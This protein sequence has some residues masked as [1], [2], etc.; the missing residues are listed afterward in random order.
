M[1]NID[2][3]QP[4]GFPLEAD[5][6]LGFM[7]SNY[8]SPLKA[9]FGQLGGNYIVSGVELNTNTNAFSDGFIWL[10]GQMIEFQGGLYNSPY[11]YVETT[12]TPKANENG[13]LVNRYTKKLAKIGTGA[14]YRPLTDLKRLHK[15]SVFQNA[16]LAYLNFDDL[17]VV[18]QGCEVNVSGNNEIVLIQSGIGI[19]GGRI[20]AIPAYQPPTPVM[21]V[22][23]EKLS[24]QDVVIWNENVPLSGQPYIAFEPKASRYLRDLRIT[25]SAFVGE[26]RMI[27][28]D[29][30]D[31]LPTGIGRF[32]MK[33]W[34][35]CN[36]L[37]GTIDMRGRIPKSEVD[38]TTSEIGENGG[39]D[40]VSIGLAHMPSHNH[41]GGAVGPGDYGL[42]R[43]SA[44]GEN[45]T[46]GGGAIDATDSGQQ[47]DITT[48]PSPIPY[49][50]NNVPLDIQNKYVKLRFIQRIL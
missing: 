41:V 48:T 21:Q 23:S 3:S 27:A 30:R 13:V 15:Q 28:V 8:Q 4:N 5:A 39:A 43:R 33:G 47:P 18:I 34:A 40:T 10:D 17:P 22:Y 14:G 6:T 12:I 45:V 38:F 20:C 26:I 11:F 32:G 49:Q 29:I 37:N 50:G 9:L 16:L 44:I 24:N 35:L 1:N 31:F 7:Q 19:F 42:I 36:G 46:I 25:S 2:F